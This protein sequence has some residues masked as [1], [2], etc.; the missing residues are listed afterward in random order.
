M[1]PVHLNLTAGRE[2]GTRAAIVA[3]SRGARF[4]NT[5]TRS[6]TAY[7][8]VPRLASKR[9]LPDASLSQV[10]HSIRSRAFVCPLSGRSPASSGEQ[11]PPGVESRLPSM[12][13]RC[14]TRLRTVRR[15]LVFVRGGRGRRR[16]ERLRPLSQGS[17]RRTFDEPYMVSE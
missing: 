3:S 10:R 7:R 9:L 12:H 13:G 11:I 2:D 17:S 4:M 1:A 5:H 6:A 16:Q 8:T 15:S 14:R